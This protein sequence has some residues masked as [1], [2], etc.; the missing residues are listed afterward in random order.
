MTLIKHC[1]YLL[2]FAISWCT[3][4]IVTRKII[5]WL[6]RRGVVGKD[7]NKPGHPEVPEMGGVT[8][9]IGVYI[10]YLVAFMGRKYLKICP[11]DCVTI[12]AVVAT[13]LMVAMVGIFDDLKG[14]RKVTK[15]YIIM[16]AALPMMTLQMSRTTVMIPFVGEVEVGLFYPLILIPLGITGAANGFNMLGGFNGL[17]VSLGIVA[18]GALAVIAYYLN[19]ITALVILIVAMGA[20]LGILYYNRYPARIFIGDTGTFTIGTIIAVATII[21][22]FEFAGIIVM[23][24]HFIELLVKGINRFPSSGWQGFYK[25]GKL[26]W[27]HPRSVGLCQWIMKITNG[28]TEVRLVMVLVILEAMC[29]GIAISVTYFGLGK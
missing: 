27:Y 18:M 7:L 19:E 13:I 17:E 24:P 29:G 6:R 15:A 2:I 10:G 22:K 20:L 21:G 25:E 14:L 16:V 3:T 12:M 5:P 11:I 1:W 4:F 28:I 8:I 23:I 26:Y 9:V